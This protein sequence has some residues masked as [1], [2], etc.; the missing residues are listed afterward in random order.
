MKLVVNGAD[1]EVD[2]RHEKT[3]LL[4]VLRDILG[5]QGTKFGCGM[6][7]CGACTVHDGKAAVR[8]CQISASEAGGKVYT[9]IEGLGAGKLHPCQRAWLEEDEG[10]AAAVV[11]SYDEHGAFD[12]YNSPTYYGI[13]LYALALWRRSPPTPMFAD[14]GDRLW[15]ELWRDIARW[16]HPLRRK[17]LF[18]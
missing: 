17:A 1:V 16:W 10:F 11:D 7:I 3:P 18:I 12:E 6:G 14:W 9:T 8:S 15:R 13:D 5:L 2:D 4:W